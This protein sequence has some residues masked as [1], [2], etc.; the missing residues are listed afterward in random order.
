MVPAHHAAF[1]AGQFGG[2]HRPSDRVW[3]ADRPAEGHPGLAGQISGAHGGGEP[4]H[5]DHAGVGRGAACDRLLPRCP[6]L[7]EHPLRK[8][9]AHVLFQVHPRQ[10]LPFLPEIPHRGRGHAAY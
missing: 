1:H 7:G 2:R 5:L 10:G 9:A 6:R 4:H 8:H 3:Q